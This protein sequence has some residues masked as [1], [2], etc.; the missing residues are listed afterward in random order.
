MQP[1]YRPR[2][3]IDPGARVDFYASSS[4]YYDH[5]LPVYRATQDDRRGTFFVSP[6]AEG[7]ALTHGAENTV[8]AADQLPETTNP[9]LVASYRDLEFALRSPRRPVALM[10]HGA[11]FSFGNKNPSYA[12]GW[13]DRAMVGLF[14][15]TNEYVA[16]RNLATFPKARCPVVGCP[17]LDQ[18]AD[19]PP[20]RRGKKPVIAISFHWACRVTPETGGAFLDFRSALPALAERYTVLGHGHPRIMDRLTLEYQQHGIEVVHDFSEIVRRA[21]LYINDCSSTLYEFAYLDRP[22]VVMNSPRYRRNIHF[23]LRFWEHSNVGVNC[24]HPSDL[25]RAVEKALADPPEQKEKRCLAVLATYPVRGNAAEIAARELVD[26]VENGQ[27][28]HVSSEIRVSGGKSFGVFYIPRTK[29]EREMCAASIRTVKQRHP[30]LRVAVASPV[31]VQGADTM[32]EDGCIPF[33]LTLYLAPDTQVVGDLRAGFQA[34]D[35]GW[36]VCAAINSHEDSNLLRYD[37]GLLFCQRGVTWGNGRPT[38]GLDDYL[39]GSSVAVWTL[40]QEWI[41]ED[42]RVAHHV[43]RRHK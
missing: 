16:Y 39:H 26:W 8:L 32:V 25:L 18:W 2:P 41:N 5:I 31:P 27:P 9:V 24:D 11:G 15:C 30:G 23:G 6:S 36:D 4:Q 35:R 10:E 38:D 34:L 40:G 3:I 20:K 7:H 37:D 17:K 42:A 22:V 21:D 33:D 29:R 43:L 12:G 19:L 28:E 1:E 13:G 14:L